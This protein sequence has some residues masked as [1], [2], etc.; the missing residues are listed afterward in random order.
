MLLCR[1][2]FRLHPRRSDLYIELGRWSGARLY[3]RQGAS[4]STGLSSCLEFKLLDIRWSYDLGW[5]KD[6]FATGADSVL[7]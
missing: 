6:D 2:A 1:L 5:A 3:R 4:L 7:T